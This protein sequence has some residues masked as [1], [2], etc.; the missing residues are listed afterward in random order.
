MLTRD[1]IPQ[2]GGKLLEGR[3]LLLSRAGI[4]IANVLIPGRDE[5]K[6]MYGSINRLGTSEGSWM[7]KPLYSFTVSMAY[8]DWTVELIS[9][10]G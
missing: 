9:M 10:S 1:L 8:K 5:G 3:V 7:M 2:R 6:H 4:P